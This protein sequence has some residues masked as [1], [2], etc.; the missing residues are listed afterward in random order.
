M[1]QGMEEVLAQARRKTSTVKVCLRGDLLAEHDRL[2]ELLA[3]ARRRDDIE[4]R[5]AEA[6]SIAQ[7]IEDLEREISDTE[8]AFTFQAIGQKAWTDL[9]AL[10]PPSEQDREDGWEF[11]P[12]TFSVAAVAASAQTPAMTEEQAGRLYDL[13]TFGQWER[14]WSVCLAANVHGTDVPFSAAAS[15]VLRGYAAKSD[16]PTDTASPAASS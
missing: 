4:N 8:T 6:A 13:C 9:I 12:R 11:N 7:Q 3:E 1:A 16:S 10:H 2:E 5:P 15:A 14:I